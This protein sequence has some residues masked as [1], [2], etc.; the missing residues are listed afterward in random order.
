M[1]KD[2]PVKPPAFRR[3]TVPVPPA[4]AAP[5]LDPKVLG[6]M[7]VPA[8]GKM[9]LTDATRKNLEH[10]GWKDGDPIPPELGQRIAQLRRAREQDLATA[11]HNLP[12]GSRVK[13]ERQ[14]DI[15]ALPEAEQAELAK[16]LSDY[17]EEMIQLGAAEAREQAMAK[18][19]P[20]NQP[21]VMNAA[22]TA[23]AAAQQPIVE[24]RRR[25]PATAPEPQEEPK[26]QQAAMREALG[27]P[28][29]VP[30]LQETPPAAPE[31]PPEPPQPAPEHNHP[32]AALDTRPTTCPR[33]LWAIADEFKMEITTRD[34]Q[35]FMAALLGDGRFTKEYNV[36][37]GMYRIGLRSL[38]TKEVDLVFKQ[39][40]CDAR[41][42]LING[43]GD[44]FLK[45]EA[46]RT[47]C[48]LEY[49]SDREGNRVIDIPPLYEIKWEGDDAGLVTHTR[50]KDILERVNDHA[51]KNESLRRIVSQQYRQFQ[52]LSE[53]L[54][55]QS[56]EP[57]F[58]I[59]IE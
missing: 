14:I 37:G 3:A 13:I 53:A 35:A 36:A 5:P 10:L 32:E 38:L 16:V 19:M 23:A 22:R 48:M 44:F 55:A 59:G 31:A 47:C 2:Q 51:I 4:P 15:S 6:N 34:R 58:W 56:A 39:L 11:S 12:A 28:E 54:E 26:T 33:C 49:V 8:A 9:V 30:E 1:S 29:F 50:L 27:R 57:D 7:P 21:G 46:Y 17:K 45:L 52:R 25:A 24:F 40:N 42:S 41:A 18:K 20:S 43:D